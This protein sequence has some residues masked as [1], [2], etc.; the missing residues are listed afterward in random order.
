MSIIE[1]ARQYNVSDMTVRRRI[2]TGRLN[3]ELREGKYFIP[4]EDKTLHSKTREKEIQIDLSSDYEEECSQTEPEKKENK[5]IPIRSIANPPID[6]QIDRL[7][8]NFEIAIDQIKGREEL[9]KENFLSERRRFEDKVE[10]MRMEIENREK[11]ISDL[12]KEIEDLEI[13]V[14]IL[15]EKIY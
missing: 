8:E 2:K 7:A 12:K 15:E 6:M 5:L 4:I 10:F 9:L 1:Y 13:L 14:K 3:A 11:E